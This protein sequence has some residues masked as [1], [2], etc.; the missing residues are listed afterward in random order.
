MKIL[1]ISYENI[2]VF[3]KGFTVDFTAFDRITDDA[4]VHF[5][6]KSISTQKVIG[7]AGINA[8]G[9]T[10]ALKLIVIAMEIVAKQTNL[11]EVL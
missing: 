11:N 2:N 1:R 9:K 6:S 3:S 7:F 8:S 10:T 4:Q 5:I